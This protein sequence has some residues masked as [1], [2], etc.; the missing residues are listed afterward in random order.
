MT[1][2]T[3]ET[4]KYTHEIGKIRATHLGYED[5]GMFSLNV[6]FAFKGS[7]QGTG[8]IGLGTLGN[9]IA[10]PL[11]EAI[12]K[13]A[14]VSTWERLVGRTVYVVRDGDRWNGRIV[15]M[16]PLPTEEGEGF[17]FASDM[18]SALGPVL[19]YEVPD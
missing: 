7:G 18:G 9:S 6:D 4:T 1:T 5:H 8:H 15:G 13:A 16:A 19:G 3:T 10:G 12:L 14:G 11:I 17:V 2:T